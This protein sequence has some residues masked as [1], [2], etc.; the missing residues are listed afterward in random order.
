M[1]TIGVFGIMDQL[2]AE[3]LNVDLETYIN[4][5]DGKCTDEEATFIITAIL[6]DNEDDVSKAQ[7]MF[8]KYL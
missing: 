4:I 1:A 2:I 7:E 3:Q 8:N 6:G 5:I